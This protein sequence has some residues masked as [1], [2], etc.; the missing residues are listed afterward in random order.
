MTSHE[1]DDISHVIFSKKLHL[2]FY[3]I[4]SYLAKLDNKIG[5][6]DICLF[7]FWDELYKNKYF[8]DNEALIQIKSIKLTNSIYQISVPVKIHKLV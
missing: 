6:K 7:T 1:A 5:D 8:D 3:K 2:I 4:A